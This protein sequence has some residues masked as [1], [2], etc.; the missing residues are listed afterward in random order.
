VAIEY[1]D[2]LGD[3]VDAKQRWEVDGVQYVVD[4]QPSSIAPGQLAT[5]SIFLQSVLD[6]SID[7]QISVD[8]PKRPMGLSVA[9]PQTKVSLRAGEVGELHIPILATPEMPAG[10]YAVRLDLRGKPASRAPRVR[11]QN[12][13]SRLP[14]IPIRDFVGLEL[15]P[16]V[17]LGYSAKM[18]A[19]PNVKLTVAG[20]PEPLAEVEL[21]PYFVEVWQSTAL[22]LQTKATREFSDRRVHIVKPLTRAAI[23]A[24][25]LNESRQ[26]FAESGVHLEMGEAICISKILT[27]TVEVFLSD[28]TLEDALYVPIFKR[29]LAAGVPFDSGVWLLMKFGYEHILNLAIALSFGLLEDDRRTQ[30]WPIEEQRAAR[31]FI[32]GQLAAKEPLPMDLVYAP[33]VLAG[34]LVSHAVAI[35]G[36]DVKA[37]L[38]ALIQ[39]KASRMAELAGEDD[40]IVNLLDELLLAQTA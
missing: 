19:R 28:E 15:A 20:T 21:R 33:L 27:R 12:A 26:H 22:D 36:E 29:L 34:V 23:F 30:I 8:L 7:F 25:M 31:K 4:L 9:E 35:D 16:I 39:A 11:P 38:Q 17:N 5:L 2:I 10:S 32:T 13:K 18:N 1:P 6:T 14:A 3:L 40:Q 37:S 24:A